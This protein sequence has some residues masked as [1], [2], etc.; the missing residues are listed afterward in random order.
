MRRILSGALVA[1][2]MVGSLISQSYTMT[3]DPWVAWAP[4]WVA[5]EKGMWKKR[6]VDIEVV[7]FNGTSAAQAL[8]ARKVDFCMAMAGT[9]VGMQVGENHDVVVLA[10]IDWSHGGDKVLLKKGLQLPDL[11]GKRVGIYEESPAVFMYLQAT[12]KAVKLTTSDVKVIVIEDLDALAS[13][14]A[15][16][17]LAA[18][19]IYEPYVAAGLGKGA[20]RVVGTTADY[21]GVMPECIVAMRERLA[22]MPQ[23]HVVAMLQGWMDAVAWVQNPKNEAEFAR[24]CIEKAF[25]GEKVTPKGVKEMLQDVRIHN[26]AALRQ[27]NLGK[28]GIGQFLAA[29][30][31]FEVARVGKKVNPKFGPLF[32]PKWMTLALPIV[33]PEPPK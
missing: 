25:V 29:C 2:A 10:E 27:R 30:T 20:A 22:K 15:A 19:I 5:Q 7:C 11:K 24:I 16:G 13:Q 12:L 33:Q 6:G 28:G 26:V 32:D 21:P 4:A 17:R 8:A 1:M 23:K 3:T 31:A 14:I 18:A 9:A